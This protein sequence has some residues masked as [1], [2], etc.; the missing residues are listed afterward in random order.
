MSFRSPFAHHRYHL[1]GV[2]QLLPNI[3]AK[4]DGV[5]FCARVRIP[6]VTSLAATIPAAEAGRNM[7]IKTHR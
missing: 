7:V 6:R 1:H 4:L 5:L 2:F 3:A